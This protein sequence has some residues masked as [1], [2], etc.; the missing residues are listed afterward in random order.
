MTNNYP[1]PQLK[2][3]HLK[4]IDKDRCKV[5]PG[6]GSFEVP[7]SGGNHIDLYHQNHRAQEIHLIRYQQK[8]LTWNQRK[9]IKRLLAKVERTA[10]KSIGTRTLKP[11]G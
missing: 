5:V 1:R 8:T 7:G 9:V 3:G 6:V 2:P 4:I 10:Q 11:N